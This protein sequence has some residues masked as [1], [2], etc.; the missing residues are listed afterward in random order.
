MFVFTNGTNPEVAL[1]IAVVDD[2]ERGK[3]WGY[4]AAALSATELT[5][6]LDD[7]KVW[8]EVR[9]T[10]PGTRGTYTNGVLKVQSDVKSD[11]ATP[12]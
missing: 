7:Q 10:R 1:L 9:F 6:H 12:K 5:M 11:P 8:S 2:R 3:S 4:R